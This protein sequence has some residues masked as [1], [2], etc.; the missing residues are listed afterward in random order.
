[1]VM[2]FSQSELLKNHD[3]SEKVYRFRHHFFV[4]HLKWEALRKPDSRE[5]DEFDDESAI[6]L[7]GI[8]NDT[9][10]SYTRL[11]PTTGPH[12]LRDIYPEILQGAPCPTGPTIWEWTRCAVSP[13]RRDGRSGTDATS[14]RILLATAEACLYLGIEALLIETHPLLMTRAIEIGWH[15]RP[16]ALP[17]EYGGSP[18]IPIYAGVDE[19]TVA[20]S[21]Q[22]LGIAETVLIID[23]AS[24][25]ARERRRRTATARHD[26]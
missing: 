23:S 16:L 17:T 21:R 6:H 1:M 3:I 20:Q 4:D 11:I 7:V 8:E 9:V 5:I 24:S 13:D 26:A 22:V 12:L 10:V 15:V 14:A 18:I 25:P 2:L 19:N